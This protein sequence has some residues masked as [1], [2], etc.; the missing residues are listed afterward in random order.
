MVVLGLKT[1]SHD[2]SGSIGSDWCM[3]VFRIFPNEVCR[4]SISRQ[5]K[6]SKPN[7][8][9]NTPCW[10]LAN[11]DLFFRKF[12]PV[13]RKLPNTVQFLYKQ[14]KWGRGGGGAYSCLA[15]HMPQLLDHSPRILERSGPLRGAGGGLLLVILPIVVWRVS[16]SRGARH[17]RPT[18]S[19]DIRRFRSWCAE[20]T[21]VIVTTNGK[22]VPT[23]IPYSQYIFHHNTFWS[24]TKDEHRFHVLFFLLLTP[25][26]PSLH[27]NPCDLNPDRPSFDRGKRGH[28]VA[29]NCS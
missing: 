16:V 20:L 19:Q 8:W 22:W 11:L 25:T 14:K 27:C 24:S 28:S 29:H 10:Q 23:C 13:T 2:L 4:S 1:Y 15:F 17:H 3:T 9:R 21:H 7:G 5:L 12:M 18:T 6:L 26:F